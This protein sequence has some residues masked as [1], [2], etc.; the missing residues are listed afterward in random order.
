MKMK[1]ILA[2]A[3]V[4][5]LA[6]SISSV[7]LAASSQ[8]ENIEVLNAIAA[9]FPDKADRV[10]GVH[11]YIHSLIGSVERANLRAY[12]K[13]VMPLDDSLSTC[14]MARAYV[15]TAR[16]NID[17]NSDDVLTRV[18]T[19]FQYLDFTHLNGFEAHTN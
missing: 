3:L 17:R 6:L 4:L 8:A 19:Q 10:E 5:C 16:A 15:E 18:G 2:F 13:S 14:A 12:L 11:Y 9:E 7:A 1:K